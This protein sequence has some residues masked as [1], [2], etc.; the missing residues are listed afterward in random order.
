MQRSDKIFMVLAFAAL[1]MVLLWEHKRASVGLGPEV[2]LIPT[3]G[4]DQSKQRD[5]AL[6]GPAYLVSALPAIR[7]VDDFLPNVTVG[8]PGISGIGPNDYGDE[9]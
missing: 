6:P 1:I 2:D 4:L 7:C 9:P 3:S 5:D 8:L